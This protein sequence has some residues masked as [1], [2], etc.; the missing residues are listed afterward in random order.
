MKKRSVFILMP[1]LF[2]S[3]FLHAQNN[4][5]PHFFEHKQE[6]GVNVT[7]LLGNVLSLT[8]QSNSSLYGFMYALHLRK[9]SFR[10]S[11]NANYTKSEIPDQITGSIKNLEDQSVG[12]RLSIERHLQLMH[13]LQLNYGLDA[14]VASNYSAST[15]QGNFFKSTSALKLGGGPAMRIIYK[16]HPRVHF[17]TESTLYGANI[18][19]TN[20]LQPG[21]PIVEVTNT[22]DQEFNLALPISLYFQVLF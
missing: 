16:L 15:I 9:Y 6:I 7:K 19:N 18:F 11:G 22:Q 4:T 13:K 1:F 12:G 17:M 21:T 8:A 2:C 10:L 14:F 20:R 5:N 3:A